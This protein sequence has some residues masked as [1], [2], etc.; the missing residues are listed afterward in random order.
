ML[1]P[2]APSLAR[3]STVLPTII[4]VR[5][6]TWALQVVY[7]C[8]L[9]TRNSTAEQ[10]GRLSGHL[11]TQNTSLKLRIPPS[12]LWHLEWRSWTRVVELIWA[13][14]SFI[15]ALQ[16]IYFTPP[17]KKL[18]SK[19]LPCL[20]P[21]FASLPCSFQRWSQAYWKEV[22]HECCST[23]V[24]SRGRRASERISPCAIIIFYKIKHRLPLSPAVLPC[25]D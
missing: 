16:V 8:L 11:S 7:L 20:L 12:P 21:L 13:M 22:L 9:P 15:C 3:L 5:A 19:Y 24:H 10:A 6:S 18:T 1:A 2:S 4:S 23:Q 14:V 25:I 17:K